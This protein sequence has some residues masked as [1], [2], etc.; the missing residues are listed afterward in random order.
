[1]VNYEDTMNFTK[2]DFAM[3]V[4]GIGIYVA[5]IGADIWVA[6]NY[7]SEERYLWCC[8][9]LA[10]LF[11]SSVIVQ[12]F[13]YTW[14]KD[15]NPEKQNWI[16]A[17]HALHGGIFTRYWFAL[18]C[19]Y[20]AAFKPNSSGDKLIDYPTHKKA[21][22]AMVDISMLRLFKTYLESTP[23]LILQIHI[24]MTSDSSAYS[25]YASITM[26]FVSISCSTVDFQI[27]LRKSL[28]GKKKFT[29][30]FSKLTYFFY[31]LLTLTSWIFSIALVTVLNTEWSIVLLVLLWFGGMIWVLKQHTTFCRRKATEILYRMVVGIILI[32][33]FFNVKG[34][35]TKIPLFVY[36]ATRAFITTVIACA[37][38]FWKSCFNEK[39]HLLVLIMV[40]LALVA[41][42]LGL[43]CLI[44]YYRFFHP[45]IY[46]TTDVVDGSG[47]ETE[48]T[49]RIQ[50][51]LMQ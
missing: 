33:T 21:I 8:L 15:D 34:E 9:T 6:R 22:D 47:Q 36:Y 28:P 48:E 19:G 3:M 49:C 45:S 11:L 5:D 38:M 14:F 42:I 7:Y 51:F 40:I 23:Q 32:F 35:R 25:Q 43:I 10:T 27:A 2:L 37:S 18:K 39:I 30:M 13:S 12:V 17:V 29:W 44:L 24:V 46:Y 4:F 50:E 1:M 16:S 41:M 26:S 31:K 20:Q